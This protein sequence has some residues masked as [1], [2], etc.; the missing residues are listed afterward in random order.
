[1]AAL[2]KPGGVTEWTLDNGV[3][4]VLKPTDFE[5]DEVRF[6]AFS[7]GGTS[8]VGDDELVPA[9][10]AAT[11]IASSGLG[12][13]DPTGLQK[14]LAGKLARVDP[15]IGEAEEGLSGRGSVKDLQTLFALLYLRF[16]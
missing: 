7:P 10:T 6:F 11:V 2:E 13:L 14:A 9:L 12:D 16:T 5:E 15:F 4:V 1:V 8:L 3:R